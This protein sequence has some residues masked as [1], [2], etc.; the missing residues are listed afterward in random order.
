MTK[1]AVVGVGHMESA[2]IKG[3]K[4]NPKNHIIA[5]NLVNPR[6]SKLAKELEFELVN[7]VAD[8]VEKNPEIVIFTTPANITLDLVPELMNLDNDTIILSA[9][10]GIEYKKIKDI[11][12]NHTV[13]RIIPNIPVVINAGTIGLFIP[14]TVDQHK[15]QFIVD[16]LSQLGD[17]IPVKE[18]QLSIVGTIGGCG[19][20]FVDVFLDALGDAGVLNGLPRDLTNTLAA[21]MVKGSA[22]LAYESKTTP[23]ILRDQ[24]CS[25]GGTT[26]QGVAS[27]EQNGFRYAVIDAVN[28]AN[29]N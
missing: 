26:I 5:E 4:H 8:L 16:F 1:V 25:P 2:I 12:P 27:L 23:A 19:P 13:A 18:D 21:S 10:A 20:A 9:A 6:V 3:L 15:R 14:E 22:S 11:L 28:K 7:T 24:V 29:K 17:V